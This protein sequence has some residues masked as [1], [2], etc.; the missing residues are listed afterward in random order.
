MDLRDVVKALGKAIVS[1]ETLEDKDLPTETH[2]DSIAWY[3]LTINPFLDYRCELP[4]GYRVLMLDF[5]KRE[6]LLIYDTRLG[7]NYGYVH[8]GSGQSRGPRALS[9]LTRTQQW[10]VSQFLQLPGKAKV[11]GI[12]T[13]PLGPYPD[14]SE[15]D[16]VRGFKTYGKPLE[17]RGP[18]TYRFEPSGGGQALKG[19][20][21]FAIRPD[22]GP[23]GMDAE[24]GSFRSARS[25][26]IKNLAKP[27]AGVQVVF[28][29]HIHRNDLLAVHVPSAAG[30]GDLKG[31]DLVKSLTRVF[32]GKPGRE[33]PPQVYPGVAV[34]P[35]RVSD[36]RAPLYLN[37]TSAGPLGN[38][39]PTED[40]DAKDRV[41]APGYAYVELTPSGTIE[42]L[43]FRFPVAMTAKAGQD[44]WDLHTR[45]SSMVGV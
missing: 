26:F 13:P 2:I 5:A 35:R 6:S 29:G 17:A 37:T 27:S 20:P 7:K 12:H 11:I 23:Y 16:L 30:K 43:A 22:G 31:Q 25:E 9:C 24:Y 15:M 3:L 45:E 18:L 10:M 39:R 21:L 8:P 42:R 19:H 36:G 32:P 34:D 14:W 28:S 1:S 41:A 4:G 38:A 33:Y 40:A 44:R